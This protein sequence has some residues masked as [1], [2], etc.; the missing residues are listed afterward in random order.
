MKTIALV[1]LMM[2]V[3]AFGQNAP[4]IEVG[5]TYQVAGDQDVMDILAAQD[6]IVEVDAVAG[7]WLR[8][9]AEDLDTYAW[10]NTNQ[11]SLL[12][13]IDPVVE[14]E[15][16]T[17]ANL[18][19]CLREIA[20]LQEIYFVDNFAYTDH[21]A[22]FESYDRPGACGEIGLETVEVSENDYLIV[23]SLGDLSYQVSASG[24]I[25]P[26]R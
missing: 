12:V 13:E 2:T 26:T 15:D 1:V 7:D 19:A 23:G 24:P 20:T 25:E 22:L 10:I 18:I 14:T 8:A 21:E 16:A 6:Y 9:Y 4:F 11:L 3:A 17:V 5:Q